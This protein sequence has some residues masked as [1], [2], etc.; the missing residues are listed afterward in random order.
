MI[1]E[2]PSCIFIEVENIVDIDDWKS[3]SVL[4]RMVTNMTWPWSIVE[5]QFLFS[6]LNPEVQ[7][8]GASLED[9]TEEMGGF[10]DTCMLFLASFMGFI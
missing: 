5:D 7:V 2:N 8:L 10:C 9:R 1:H 3:A 6:S 4:V